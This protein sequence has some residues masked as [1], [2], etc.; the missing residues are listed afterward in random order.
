MVADDAVAE[1]AEDAMFLSSVADDA[2]ITVTE[3]EFA[4]MPS[5]CQSTSSDDRESS[6]HRHPNPEG[7][8]QVD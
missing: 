2:V 4:Y 3:D 1:V 5:L 7:E 8:R 6:R